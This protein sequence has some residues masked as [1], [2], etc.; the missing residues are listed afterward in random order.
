[1]KVS[2]EHR[3]GAP[4]DVVWRALL[5]PA[6]L[7]KTLPG[8]QSLESTGENQ[9][10][11]KLTLKVGP[12]Q[13]AFSGKVRLSELDPP[14]GYRV[15]IDGRGAPGFVNGKGKIEL[16]EVAGETLLR[17]EIDAQVGGRIA[18]VGQ[19]LLDSSAKVLTRQGIEG[20][21]AQIRGLVSNPG[22]A[23]DTRQGQGET[24]DAPA[25]PAAASSEVSQ[26]RFALRFLAGLAGEMV[27]RQ[28]RTFLAVVLLGV[29]LVVAF[30]SLRACSG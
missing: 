1:M 9:F 7:A 30:V 27:P 16:E 17:Y 18:G 14:S 12:V 26:T 21:D 28:R 6:V 23:A 19:R 22:S 24:E 2:G 3:L 5:D 4:R 11:G 8:C 10:E 13:G 15:A 20:L 29:V 25:R